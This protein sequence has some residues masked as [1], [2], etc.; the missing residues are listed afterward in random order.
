MKTKCKLHTIFT[1]ISE[2]AVSIIGN[3]R[4]GKITEATS[5]FYEIIDEVLF[6][7]YNNNLMKIPKIKKLIE[8][9]R[10]NR[11]V[12]RWLSFEY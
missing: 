10:E 7:N 4:L 9:I 6:I 12:R 5:S 1:L 8:E 2:G 3:V 11:F